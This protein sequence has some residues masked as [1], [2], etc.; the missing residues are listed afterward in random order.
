MGKMNDM[1]QTIEEL[2]NAAAIIADAAEWL[3]Y[4]FSGGDLKEEQPITET[5]E[6]TLESVRAVLADKSRQGYAAEVRE[7]IKKY[8][9]DKLSAVNPSDYTALLAEAEVIGNAG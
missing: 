7:L 9:A 6:L 5:P 2:R 4:Q 1:A 8:G 3:T